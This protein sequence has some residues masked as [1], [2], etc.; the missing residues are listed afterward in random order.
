[1]QTKS[2]ILLGS[3]IIVVEI[4]F[5]FIYNS[6]TFLAFSTGLFFLLISSFINFTKYKKI[7]IRKD[8]SPIVFLAVLIFIIITDI[9]FYVD[10]SP[11]LFLPINVALTLANLSYSIWILRNFFVLGDRKF[12]SCQHLSQV[13]IFVSLL[14]I[15][16]FLTSPV[17]SVIELLFMSMFLSAFKISTIIQALEEISRPPQKNNMS[18]KSKMD[19]K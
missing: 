11:F 12:S 8:L 2:V 18:F 1:M 16:S 14:A 15:S 10:N 9:I 17:I 7:F 19:I 5:L 6:Q 4:A 13:W 3:S